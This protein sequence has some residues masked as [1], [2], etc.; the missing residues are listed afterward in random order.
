[1]RIP[2]EMDLDQNR[3]VTFHLDALENM[4]A[5]VYLEDSLDNIHYD[6]SENPAV[7]SLLTGKYKDR[8]FISFRDRTVLSSDDFTF[9]KDF[10][11]FYNDDLEEIKIITKNDALISSMKM[12]TVLGQEIKS[13]NFSKEFKKERSID[14]SHLP[15]GLFIIRLET[16]K[17]ILSK[18][19]I[20]NK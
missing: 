20:I 10:T 3:E 12:Y 17:G 1:M 15:S 13:Y 2:L 14:V 18:K 9:N 5:T 7:L 4:N 8:F 19:L 6:L 11:L 16:N